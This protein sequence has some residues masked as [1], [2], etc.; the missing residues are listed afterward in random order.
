MKYDLIIITI[1]GLY[2]YKFEKESLGGPRPI[3]LYRIVGFYF[4]LEAQI[5]MA[6]MPIVNTLLGL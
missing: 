5:K 2:F 3:I 4:E 6:T 1:L